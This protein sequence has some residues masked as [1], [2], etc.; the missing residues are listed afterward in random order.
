MTHLTEAI[1]R[2]RPDQRREP[3]DSH[4]HPWAADLEGTDVTA[5][6]RPGLE[7]AEASVA[8]AATDF[9]LHRTRE[10]ADIR[11]LGDRLV[12]SVPARSAVERLQPRAQQQLRGLIERVFL[13]VSGEAVR[14]VGLAA[15]GQGVASAPVTAALT[16]LLAQQTHAHV[17]A[18]DA[19]G[20]SP[21]LYEQFGIR[22]PV[23]R[24]GELEPGAPLVRLAHEGRRHI[25][26]FSMGQTHLR[27]ALATDPTGVGLA[28]LIGSFDYVL[29][30][31]E[32]AGDDVLNH[33]V[34]RLVDG[35]ILVIDAEVTRPSIAQRVVGVLRA[36]GVTILGAV[37]TNR[38]YPV[39]APIY[40][41]L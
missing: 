17:C 38:R 32:P 28:R 11:P 7:P 1:R 8:Y 13:P 34:I 21:T 19:S 39:P 36:A 37:L 33:A 20:A 18:I 16:E 30:D 14:S 31:L 23:A 27:P 10:H 5:G 25:S 26:V 9:S 4:D 3:L 40:Q 2:A 15:V 22:Q 41:R 12:P 29:I 35:V 24:D 6:P